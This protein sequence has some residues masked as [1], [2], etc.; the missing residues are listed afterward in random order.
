MIIPPPAPRSSQNR[1][2]R[3][4]SSGPGPPESIASPRVESPN[5]PE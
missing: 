2:N 1:E 3:G 5:C 4:N